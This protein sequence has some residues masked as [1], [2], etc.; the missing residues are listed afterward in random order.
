MVPVTPE[1]LSRFGSL[2]SAN[3]RDLTA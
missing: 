3:R 1:C 2:L